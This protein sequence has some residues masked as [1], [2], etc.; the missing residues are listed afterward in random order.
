M[1][2]ILFQCKQKLNCGIHVC[3][4]SCHDRKDCPQCTRKSQQKCLCG[5]S[6]QERNCNDLV[7]RCEKVL[8]CLKTNLAPITNVLFLFCFIFQVCN[9]KYQCGLHKCEVKCHPTG[10]C[11]EC[12]LGLPRECPCG[13][14]VHHPTMLKFILELI[15]IAITLIENASAMY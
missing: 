10:D 9:K 6:T 12:P 14:E 11:G 4:L 5:N 3:G 1:Y 15:L 8:F 7:W 13:K 2:S